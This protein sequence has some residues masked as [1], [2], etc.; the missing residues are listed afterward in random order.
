MDLDND[1]DI[2]LSLGQNRDANPATIN[3]FSI[4]LVND[5]TGHYPERIELPR[6]AFNEGYTSVEAQTHFDVN[7]DGFQDLLVVHVR[8]NDALPDVLPFTGRYIQVLLNDD[9]EAFVDET[10]TWM[11]DQSQPFQGARHKN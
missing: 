4:V 7:S 9:G 6:P 5:G 8:N 10:S 3:Q 11:G 1:G 2:D